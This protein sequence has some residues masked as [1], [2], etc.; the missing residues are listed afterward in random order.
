M[1]GYGALL[2]GEHQPGL[3][4]AVAAVSPTGVDDLPGGARDR[5]NAGAFAPESLAFPAQHPA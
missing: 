5:H 2:L 3:L 1:G 4:S